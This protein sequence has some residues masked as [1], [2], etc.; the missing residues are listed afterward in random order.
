MSDLI[1]AQNTSQF[2]CYTCWTSLGANGTPLNLIK[3][4]VK[5][6]NRFKISFEKGAKKITG[7]VVP[8]QA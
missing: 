5:Q 8:D 4:G 3:E 2:N 6:T 7:H 1:K